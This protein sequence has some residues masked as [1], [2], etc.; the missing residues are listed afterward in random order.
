MQTSRRKKHDWYGM[1]IFTFCRNCGAT[2]LSLGVGYKDECT[3]PKQ[4]VD[5]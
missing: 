4:E 1:G 5:K 2:L 3:P